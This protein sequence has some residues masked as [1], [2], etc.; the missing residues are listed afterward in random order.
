MRKLFDDPPNI[1]TKSTTTKWKPTPLTKSKMRALRR[2]NLLKAYKKAC[3]NKHI[4]E[5][6]VKT[7][8]KEVK[9]DFAPK[10][11]KNKKE[12]KK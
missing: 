2:K 10:K 5:S 7:M 6:M 11:R 9:T 8:I 4:S 1:P 12:I 3:K